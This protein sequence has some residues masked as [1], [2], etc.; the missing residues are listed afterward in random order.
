MWIEYNDD[1]ELIITLSN[2]KR[3][4]YFGVS[5]Y[6]VKRIN[7]WIKRKWFGRVFK[8]LKDYRHESVNY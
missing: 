7:Y 6:Q 4:S 3:Y 1:W 5:P 2:G 8:L